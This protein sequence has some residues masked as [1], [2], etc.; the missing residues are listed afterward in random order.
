LFLP[1]YSP[2]LNLIE[3]LWKFTKNKALYGRHYKTFD[4]FQTAIDGCLD[5]VGIEHRAALKLL[6][7]HHFQTFDKASFLAA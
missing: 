6:M 2:N 5:R 7:T 3:R 4:A 1:G